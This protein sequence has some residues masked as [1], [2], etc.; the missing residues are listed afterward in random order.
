MRQ[1]HVGGKNFL[2]FRWRPV[3]VYDWL[4]GEAGFPWICVA[5]IGAPSFTF[6]EAARSKGLA[7]WISAHTA[8]LAEGF[9]A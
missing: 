8:T 4:T 9:F 5:V 7:N 1:A 3:E 2:P 6:A